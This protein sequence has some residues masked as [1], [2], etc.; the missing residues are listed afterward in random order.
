MTH[1]AVVAC[2]FISNVVVPSFISEIEDKEI[3][4]NIINNDFICKLVFVETYLP[5]RISDLCTDLYEDLNE[6]QENMEYT[7]DELYEFLETNEFYKF[8]IVLGIHKYFHSDS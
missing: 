1:I 7:C 2:K 5:A 4:R 3:D 6:R 8:Q